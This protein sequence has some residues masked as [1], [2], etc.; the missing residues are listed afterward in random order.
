[1]G[2]EDAGAPRAGPMRGSC[3]LSLEEHVECRG[4]VFRGEAR[5]MIHAEIILARRPSPPTTNQVWAGG[6]I[7]IWTIFTRN[8]VREGRY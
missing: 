2:A 5:N 4:S 1:M 6:E 8:R 3:I 7:N